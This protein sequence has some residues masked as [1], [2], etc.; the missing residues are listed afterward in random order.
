MC[1]RIICY[2]I[3]LTFRTQEAAFSFILKIKRLFLILMLQMLIVSILSSIDLIYHILQ[4]A[5]SQST[6]NVANGILK[7]AETVI[8]QKNFSNF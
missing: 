5:V 2:I 7:T 8:P 6:A 3:A 4:N 1:Q